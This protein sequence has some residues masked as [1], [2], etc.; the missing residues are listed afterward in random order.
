MEFVDHY[1]V[2][3]SGVEVPKMADTA[4]GLDGRKQDVGVGDLRLAR[5]ESEVRFTSDAP[6]GLHRLG[7]DFFAM[8]DEEN[9]A[10]LGPVRVECGKPCLAEARR[11]DDEA[12]AIALSATRL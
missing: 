7:E 9:P 12:S 2:E 1:V 6:I 3:G 5:V 8:R 10:E 11:Q 4:E